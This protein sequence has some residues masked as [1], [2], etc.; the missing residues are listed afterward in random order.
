MK[1]VTVATQKSGYYPLL[2][3]SCRKHGIVLDTL[4]LGQPWKGFTMKFRL[5]QQYLEK[6][7]LDEIIMFVDAYDVVVLEDHDVIV[8]K[9]KRFQKEIVFGTQNDFFNQFVFPRCLGNILNSGSY[10]GY[11]RSLQKL[12]DIVVENID[13][14][15]SDQRILNHACNLEKYQDFY[16]IATTP[17]IKCSLFYITRADNYFHP[18][19]IFQKKIDRL[20]LVKNR[21]YNHRDNN[22]PSVI[23]LPGHLNGNYYFQKLGYQTNHLKIHNRW[24][25]IRQLL[26]LGRYVWMVLLAILVYSIIHRS[27]SRSVSR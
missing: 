19:Y 17:D 22:F 14:S 3:E 10:L 18:K 1:V 21:I 25:K 24:Y 23:H 9:F 4:G 16:R 8:D 5:F 20:E 27:V 6:Q 12:V 15:R 7:P 26:Y 2:V 11:C 13:F